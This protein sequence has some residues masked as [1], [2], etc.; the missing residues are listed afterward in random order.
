MH[1]D[2]DYNDL[3]LTANQHMVTGDHLLQCDEKLE[4][5]EG[6]ETCLQE[7]V[8][9]D[10]AFRNARTLSK[11]M[12]HGRR[13][14]RVRFWSIVHCQVVYDVKSLSAVNNEV[15]DCVMV[16]GI[17]VETCGLDLF[18]SEVNCNTKSKFNIPS[19]VWERW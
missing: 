3:S 18:W 12:N 7:R 11:L 16:L 5:P 9:N 13:H 15:N 14:C 17:N 10:F 6:L 4:F 19:S 1:G 2:A 8:L